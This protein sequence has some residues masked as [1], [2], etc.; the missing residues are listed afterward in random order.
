MRR[1][2][3]KSTSNIIEIIEHIEFQLSNL[4][5]AL[6]ENNSI[7]RKKNVFRS[8]RKYEF[9]GMWKDR[10]DMKGLSSTE[11]LAKLRRKQWSKI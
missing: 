5:K 6:R 1:K 3:A 9:C 11:W 8:V 10:E 2:N 4:R 7:E